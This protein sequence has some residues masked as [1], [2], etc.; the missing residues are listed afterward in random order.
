[1]TIFFYTNWR[2]NF[3]K[4]RQIKVVT[5]YITRGNFK[6]S[7]FKYFMCS[8][9]TYTIKILIIKT[10]SNNVNYTICVLYTALT[11]NTVSKNAN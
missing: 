10:I 9:S 3:D 5:V 11:I 2:C 7:F 4:T 8:N 1:M 6:I